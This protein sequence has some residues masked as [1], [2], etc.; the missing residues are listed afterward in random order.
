MCGS[1]GMP[2]VKDNGA[3][4]HVKMSSLEGWEDDRMCLEEFIL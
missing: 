4:T 1:S 2:R 3:E